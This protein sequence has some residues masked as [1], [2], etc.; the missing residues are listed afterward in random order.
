VKP[1]RPPSRIVVRGTNWV[2]DTVMSIPAIREVRRIFP[3]TWIALWAPVGLKPLL[4]ATGVPDD[5]LGVDT[6][7]AGPLKRP[8]VMRRHL[9]SGAFD[10]AVLLQNA[11]ESAFTS[12]LAGIPVR[13]GYPT[14]LRGP[15]LNVKA[16]LTREIRQ[17]HQ[18]FYY[19]GITDF[20][21]NRFAT[22][23]SEP[24]GPP[25][26]SVSLSHESLQRARQLLAHLGQDRPIFCLCP[27]SVNSEA[28]RWP[29]D[30]FAR[31]ADLLCARLGSAVVF[32]GARE[33]RALIDGIIG[34]MQEH[35]AMNLA[36]QTDLIGSMA[37]MRVSHMVVSND[38][39]SAHM[40]VAAGSTVLTVFG[41]TSVGATAPYGPTAFT[42]QGEALCAPCRHF[43]CPVPGH[44]CMRSLAPEDVL[45][46]IVE[47]RAAQGH[48]I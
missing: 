38:T 33:E 31:L 36:G 26:C 21:R 43:R 37:I 23:D 22:A 30:Y 45:R 13:A 28:K 44:P 32:L 15:L 2:G 1:R 9:V 24:P 16:P 42:V 40:A 12:F 10:M 46:K 29:A 20:I 39:G 14:D 7:A 27:G 8:F 35:G 5:V 4:C 6:N 25:D 17:K 47:I 34:Q 3:S 48:G 19:L 18:V 41:P 11:F